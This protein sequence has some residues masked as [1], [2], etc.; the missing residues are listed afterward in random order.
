MRRFLISV[1]W[2]IATLLA[3]SWFFDVAF[4]FNLFGRAHW[5]YLSELQLSGGVVSGFYISVAIFVAC[6]LG[7][8]YILIVPWHRRIDMLPRSAIPAQSELSPPAARRFTKPPKLNMGA[9][10]FIPTRRE[11]KVMP[12]QSVQNISSPAFAPMPRPSLEIANGVMDVLT[13]A[14]FIMKE[15]PKIGDIRPD[16]WGVG[17]DEAILVGLLGDEGDGI[18]AFEGGDSMWTSGARKFKSPAWKTT[19]VVQKLQALL[20]E[21]LDPELKVNLLPFV[22]SGGKILNR[23][24]VQGVW[25]ALGVKVFDDMGAFAGFIDKHRPRKLDASEMGDLD[26]FADFVDTVAG[27]FNGGA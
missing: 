19:A 22:Y 17:S 15:P 5:R 23:D 18:M 8:L 24:G 7:G 1:L 12:D 9:G 2:A 13:N 14:G 20:A 21:V 27:Y 16:F 10:A 6:F 11:E 3:A 25:D 4:G 26:A